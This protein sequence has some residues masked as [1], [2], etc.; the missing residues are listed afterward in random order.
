MEGYDY[1]LPG[2][3]FVTL[4]S[5]RRACLFG[6]IKEEIFRQSDIGKLIN[7]CWLRIPNYFN[8]IGLDDYVLMPNHLHG[9]ILIHESVGK[10]EAF[11]DLVSTILRIV[12]ANASPQRPKGTQPGSLGAII[13][14]FKSISTRMVN[15]KYF[16]SG[17]KLWQRNYHERIIRNDRELNAIRQY[18]RDNPLNWELDKKNP[19][20]M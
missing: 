2:A 8:D 9:I 3:Y 6:Q 18:I 10:G 11:A 15:K 5:Y 17:N 14:N 20:N 1:S 16:E 12:S 4:L 13:Q 7:D 19:T